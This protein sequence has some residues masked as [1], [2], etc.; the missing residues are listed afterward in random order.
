M[1]PAEKP[2]NDLK[3]NNQIV[4]I[5]SCKNTSPILFSRWPWQSNTLQVTPCTSELE[6]IEVTV[7]EK[8]VLVLV[9]KLLGTSCYQASES[10]QVSRS[11]TLL[12]YLILWS[13]SVAC[14]RKFKKC[15][16]VLQRSLEKLLNQFGC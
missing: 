2:P 7:L 15:L 3:H 8:F 16:Q 10:T 1:D 13:S 14:I 6:R 12:K 5:A 4:D 11:Y 9:T